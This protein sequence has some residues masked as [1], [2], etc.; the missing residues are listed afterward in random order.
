MCRVC[1]PVLDA[2]V[3][4]FLCFDTEFL[5][6]TLGTRIVPTHIESSSDGERVNTI[7]FETATNRSSEIESLEGHVDDGDEDCTGMS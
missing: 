3:E 1:T 2:S 7:Q 6:N 5:P 4:R